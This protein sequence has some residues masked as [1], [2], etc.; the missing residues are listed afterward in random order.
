[1]SA[2]NPI[3]FAYTRHDGQLMRAIIEPVLEN[4]TP[5][6]SYRIFKDAADDGSSL[7]TD[8]QLLRTENAP[9]NENDPDYLGTISFTDGQQWL[10]KGQV[11]TAS[12]QQQMATHILKEL[13]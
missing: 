13:L 7:I 10:Y 3:Q 8:T 11:L 1:M 12:E 2:I 5:T 9:V 4:G 6:K